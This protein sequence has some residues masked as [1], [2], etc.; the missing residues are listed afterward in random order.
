MATCG[1]SC[2]FVSR[3]AAQE[4]CLDDSWHQL[5]SKKLSKRDPLA[6]TD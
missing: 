2:F 3:P 4:A 5:L 6:E 1:L